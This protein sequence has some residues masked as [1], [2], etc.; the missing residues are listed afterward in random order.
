MSRFLCSE[1]STGRGEA[2]F[3][4]A[5]R[6]DRW[7]C[8]EQP[9]PWGPESVPSSRLDADVMDAL[10]GRA[11]EA[12]A[13]LVLIRRP[14]GTKGERRTVIVADSRPG[15]ERALRTTVGD[16][17][18][19]AD[20]PLPYGGDVPAGWTTVTE[21]LFLVCT[22]GRHDPCCAVRG[23]PVAAV[24]SA[25][26]PEATWETS[27]VGGDRFAANVVVL[28]AGLYLGRVDT[29]RVDDIARDVRA[30]R[31]PREH[32]RGRSAF[33]TVVQAAQHF[34]ADDPTLSTACI[35]D[36][37]PR[38]ID[39]LGP[40]RWRVLLAAAPHDVAVEVERVTSD[41]AW[42]LTCHAA[43]EQPFP[44]YRLLGCAPAG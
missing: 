17:A 33:S 43:K 35:T 18:E 42:R 3:A 8:V 19:L 7:L 40:D 21:P 13:R 6:V 12:R 32:F 5:S 9:G 39:D 4:T 29:S 41:E 26:A 28:P 36:L 16:D 2:L 10:R 15:R 37:V 31:V 11:R 38:R 22:H 1:S 27:H 14:G 23:R 24:L 44:T 30:G 25:V 20:L 34:A